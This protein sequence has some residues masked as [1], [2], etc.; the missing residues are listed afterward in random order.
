MARKR[1]RGYR[2]LAQPLLLFIVSIVLVAC[3]SRGPSLEMLRASGELRVA[4]VSEPHTYYLEPEG[5]LGFDYELLSE[6]CRALGVRLAVTMVATRELAKTMVA[7]RKVH[8][9]A[10][11][12]PVTGDADPRIRYGP[13]YAMLRAQVIYLGENPSPDSVD[14][15]IGANIETLAGGLGAAELARVAK[16]RTELKYSTP[17]GASSEQLLS[18]VNAGMIDYAVIPSIDFMVLRLKYPALEIGFELG[19]LHATAWAISERSEIDVDQ[20]VID[21]FVQRETDGLRS[22]LWDRYYGHHGP[23]DSVEAEAF[24]GAYHERFPTVRHFF[25]GAGKT[26]GIDWRLLAA[27]SYQESHWDPEARSPT[28]VRGLMMLTRRTA[29]HLQVSRLDPAE[30]VD[31]GAR[32]L[33]ELI[34]R[35]PAT[36][37]EDDRLWFGLAAYN[38]GLG[39]LEDARIL[40]ERRGGNPNVWRDVRHHLPL[41]SKKSVASTLRYGKARG[42][43]TVHFVS[44]IRRYFDAMRQLERRAVGTGDADPAYDTRILGVL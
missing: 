34:A 3:D 18:R 33:A 10:G 32:Y 29:K 42:G 27:L 39:H 40:T 9:A 15:L 12:I 7:E 36:I 17:K 44:S 6:F 4:L 23:F 2:H 20:A 8:L 31:G 26:V 38:V 35:L 43:E 24:L 14:D 28:G 41:L 22:Q 25:W 21:F 11:L 19:D 1:F 16:S 13:S 5:I 37:A 30:S